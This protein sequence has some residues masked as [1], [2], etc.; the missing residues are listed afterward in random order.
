DHPGVCP[1][2]LENL[3]CIFLNKT[4]CNRDSDCPKD[5]KCCLSGD[6]LRCQVVNNEKSGSCPIP[7]TRCKTP[8]PKPLCTSDRDCPG[9]KK[10]CSPECQ[11]K[12]TDPL[13][14]SESLTH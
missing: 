8:L 10:C 4:L 13:Q 5:Q 14:V 6:V 11:R 7:V 9:D 1:T 3:S 12:C 2:S